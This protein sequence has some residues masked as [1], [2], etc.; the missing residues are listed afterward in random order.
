MAYPNGKLPASAL[1]AV[2]GVQL[3][4][5]TARAWDQ[6]RDDCREAVGVDI[7][8]ALPDGG[9]RS[10][11]VQGRVGAQNPDSQVAVAA[12]GTSTHGWGTRVDVGSFP[13]AHDLNRW[14]Q[15]GRRRRAWLLEHM[16]TYG[17]DREFGEADPNHLRHDGKTVP[18]TAA[19]RTR[20]IRAL[21]LNHRAR[22]NNWTGADGQVVQSSTATTGNIDGAY[23]W[24]IKKFGKA[25]G[26]YGGKVT[27]TSNP[28]TVTALGKR[29]DPEALA[30]FRAR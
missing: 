30:W 7:W 21:Y 1:A 15:D 29:L 19:Q 20:K 16:H 10:L 9:Y 23:N 17:F 24:L 28:A 3:A 25:R 27:T 11:A 14:G 4:V 6:M 18:L 13:P 26:W 5:K 8:P 12:P 22:A 2:Q